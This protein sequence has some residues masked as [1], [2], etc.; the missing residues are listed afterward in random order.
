MASLDPVAAIRAAAI[1]LGGGRRDYD[2]LLDLVGDARF[3]LLGEATHG[4]H[5]FY[6]ERA[7]ITQR[8]IEEKGF[9]AVAV[10]ADWPDAY[11][12]NRYVR[13]QS[14]DAD[15]D[16]ALSG[17]ERFPSW[18]WRNTDVSAFV[19]WLR[20]HNAKQAGG[21][22]VGF[23]GLDLYSLFTSLR[24]VL[25]YLDK[26]DP[27]AAKIARERYA[28]FDHYYEDSQH[29]GYSANLDLSASC[30]EGVIEQLNQMQRRAY[31]Y[32]QRD[33]SEDGFFYA[34]QNARLVKNAEEYYRTMFRGRVSSWNLRDSHMAETLEALAQHLSRHGEPARIVVWEHNSHIGDA[35]ATEVGQLGE[36]NVGELA[37]KAYDGQTRLI[38]F[39]TYE[40]FVTAASEWDGPAE[41]KRVRPGMPGS[42]EELL[43]ETGIERFLLPLSGNNAGDSPAREAL[44]QRRLERAIGVIYLPR[45]ER[46]SHYFS[47]QMA[48]QFDAVIHIDRTT[49]VTPLDPGGGWHSEEPPETYPGGF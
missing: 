30:E 19:D 7:R 2:E 9:H 21:K 34:Q 35:R 42:Y 33:G 13:G 24:E 48:V 46:Q 41:H 37:R 26:V 38:G 45:T 18:M 44:M 20:E 27:Q 25:A 8:L 5:E 28:C 43:H 14:D 15:A 17:F 47:A 10:E 40:G 16:A 39:S 6:E 12:V 1:P 29:Y 49:A 3:V 4:T 11:R 22:A 31:E 32:S 23:Y 36:W